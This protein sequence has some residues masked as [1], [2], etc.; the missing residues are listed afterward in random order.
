MSYSYQNGPLTYGPPQNTIYYEEPK[1]KKPSAMPLAIGST[2]IG[3]GAGAII[4][5]RKNPYITKK[6]EIKDDFA[7]STYEKYLDKAG[8]STKKA[9]QGGLEILHKIDSVKTPEELKALFD[10][11]P[12]AAKD[13]CNELKQNPNEYLKRINQNNLNANKKMIK[14]KI[15]TSNNIRIRDMKNQIE[16][17][18]NQNNKKFEKSD[19]VTKEVFDVIKKSTNKTKYKTIGKYAAIGAGIAGVIGFIT[20]KLLLK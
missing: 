3:G 10:N 19:N 16:S 18:W 4:G 8:N 1:Y 2:I 13:V 11:N 12:E 5:S 14:E 15:N 20:G 7:K 9:Y 17:C 6:G